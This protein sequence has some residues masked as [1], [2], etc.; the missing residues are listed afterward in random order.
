MMGFVNTDPRRP[1]EKVVLSARDAVEEAAKAVIQG[2]AVCSL[3]MKPN[4]K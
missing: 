4:R 3:S 2:L 1:L